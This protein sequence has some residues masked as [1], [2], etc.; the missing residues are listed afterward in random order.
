MRAAGPVAF[1]GC[2][3]TEAAFTSCDLSD[4]VFSD[5]TLKLTEFG[6]GRYRDT[7]LRGNDLRTARGIIN[8]AKIRIDHDQQIQLAEALMNELDITIGDD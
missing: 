1:A 6:T 4:V 8:L 3:F 5:C 2:T 7:D